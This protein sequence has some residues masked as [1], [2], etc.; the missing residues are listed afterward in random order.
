MRRLQTSTQQ[1]RRS[2][3]QGRS[4]LGTTLVRFVLV[5]LNDYLDPHLT[6]VLAPFAPEGQSLSFAITFAWQSLP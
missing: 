3:Q 2:Y 6:L 4:S 5:L 1:R